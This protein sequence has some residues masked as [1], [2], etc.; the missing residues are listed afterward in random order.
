LFKKRQSFVN[1]LEID[2]SQLEISIWC[3]IKGF[4]ELSEI[5]KKNYDLH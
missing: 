1:L 3:M 5:S 4:L 2:I